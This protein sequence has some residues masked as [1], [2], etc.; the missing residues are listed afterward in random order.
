MLPTKMRQLTLLSSTPI[1]ERAVQLK[2][3]PGIELLR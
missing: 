3:L 2:A 1:P